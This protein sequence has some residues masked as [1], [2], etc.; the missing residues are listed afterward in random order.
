MVRNALFLITMLTILSVGT[1]GYAD[2][3]FRCKGSVISVGDYASEVLEKCGEPDHRE[4]WQEE[5]YSRKSQIFD[6]ENERYREPILIKSPVRMERW[7]YNLGSQQFIRYLQF[8]NSEL[9]NI[10][11]GDKGS[12]N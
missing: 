11:T 12:N 5:V 9:I 4:K 6:H 3:T 2:R 8:Q 10:E 7:T 1:N